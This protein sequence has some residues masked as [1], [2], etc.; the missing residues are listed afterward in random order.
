MKFKNDVAALNVLEKN[1]YVYNG[2]IFP[3][4]EYVIPTD[5]EQDATRYLHVEWDY[6]VSLISWSEMKRTNSEN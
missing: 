1:F 6:D 4:T 2:T 5:H 3:R